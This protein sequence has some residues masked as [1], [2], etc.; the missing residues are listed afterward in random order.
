[1]CGEENMTSITFICDTEDFSDEDAANW[2]QV[3]LEEY[4]F[5]GFCNKVLINKK[6]MWEQPPL[7][8]NIK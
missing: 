7:P 8:Q 1:M 6:K 4:G 3:V 2:I 5:K